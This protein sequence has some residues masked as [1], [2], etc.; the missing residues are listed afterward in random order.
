MK[1]FT[2]TMTLDKPETQED[3][4]LT[5]GELYKPV[6]SLKVREDMATTKNKA[7]ILEKLPEA[8]TLTELA[9]MAGV[10]RWTIWSYLTKDSNFKQ[11][12]DDILS[13]ILDSAVNTAKLN[14]QEV[15]DV[16][17]LVALDPN[18][19][20]WLGAV[21][22]FHR[23]LE[24]RTG[25]ADEYEPTLEITGEDYQEILARAMAR[26]EKRKESRANSQRD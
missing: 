7:L 22:E 9:E 23:I 12:W 11:K 19:K 6:K 2:A 24:K 18:H 10:S 16:L 8:K 1:E 15:I 5:V 20:E 21:K 3:E 25:I 26:Q 14:S 13:F 17:S 4:G